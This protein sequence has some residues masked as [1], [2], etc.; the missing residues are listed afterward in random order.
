MVVRL[1]SRASRRRAVQESRCR[2]LTATYNGRVMVD[3]AGLLR[4]GRHDRL[5]DRPEAAKENVDVDMIAKPEN[6]GDLRNMIAVR[7][8]QLWEDQG[9]PRGSDV[10][11]WYQAE[12]EILACATNGSTSASPNGHAADVRTKAPKSAAK[13]KAVVEPKPKAAPRKKK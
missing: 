13:P 9:R 3:D 5:W 11:H 7:A 6:A 10:L 8:Y 12:Q 2:V 4:R 1:S